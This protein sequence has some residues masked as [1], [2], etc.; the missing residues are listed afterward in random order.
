MQIKGSR[1][2]LYDKSGVF[3][4][5]G[6]QELYLLGYEDMEEFKNYHNDFA[7]LFV[8]KPGYIFKFQN[9]SWIDYTLH[10]GTPNRKVL[11][12]TKN[13]KEIETSLTI[14][15]IFL[16]KEINGANTC[17][18]I[19]LSNA[20]FKKEL[21]NTP[22][23]DTTT[24]IESVS[25][26]PQTE[27]ISQDTTLV[28]TVDFGEEPTL[29]NTDYAPVLAPEEKTESDFNIVMN[30]VPAPEAVMG[31]KL[32]FDDAILNPEPQTYRSIDEIKIDDLDFTASQERYPDDEHEDLL[33][34]TNLLVNDIHLKKEV[35]SPD[36]DFDLGAIADELGLDISLLAQ[37]LSEYIEEIDIKMPIIQTAIDQKDF[38]VA[39]DELSKLK[40]VAHHLRIV[41]LSTQFESLEKIL[42][43]GDTQASIDALLNL[44]QTIQAFKDM[45]Q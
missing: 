45:V 17:F 2:I 25:F 42:H 8:N 30:D 33:N 40:S 34:D 26:T 20:P 37:I 12:K 6:N 28:Q 23:P 27:I 1:L 31:I 22:K 39:Q 15:E 44:T 41:Q 36:T 19:E 4:G 9:F 11:I 18:C 21:Q 35:T 43:D 38:V 24:Q 10:S 16:N 14:N 13:G 3:L 5:L 7:D 29:Y 32:K